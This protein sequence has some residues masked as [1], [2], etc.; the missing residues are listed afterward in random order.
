MTDQDGAVY[1][2]SS[3]PV[4]AD[5]TFLVVVT[6]DKLTFDCAVTRVLAIAHYQCR[7]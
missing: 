5:T 2:C 1:A 4:T 7:A 3:V 6:F